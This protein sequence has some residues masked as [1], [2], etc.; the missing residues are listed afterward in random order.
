MQ[1]VLRCRGG[2]AAPERRGRAGTEAVSLPHRSGPA[3]PSPFSGCFLPVK[4]AVI[5]KMDTWSR[6]FCLFEHESRVKRSP[7][8]P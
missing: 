4:C 1:G 5:L 6:T 3:R 7:N 8:L 2:G